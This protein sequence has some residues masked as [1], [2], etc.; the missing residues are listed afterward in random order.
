MGLRLVGAAGYILNAWIPFGNV[1]VDRFDNM[2]QVGQNSSERAIE[3]TTIKSQYT[4]NELRQ[5]TDS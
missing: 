5:A 2:I 3:I 4:R 1:T